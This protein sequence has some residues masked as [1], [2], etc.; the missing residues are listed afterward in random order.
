MIWPRT[1]SASAFS[2][3]ASP[4]SASSAPPP[5]AS[6]APSPA[7]ASLSLP[8]RAFI[9]SSFI[10]RCASWST[11]FCSVWCLPLYARR[12]KPFVTRSMISAGCTSAAAATAFSLTLE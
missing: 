6:S 5:P 9:S 1:F 3:S 12:G 11:F 10:F 8:N 7:P 2:A 4:A